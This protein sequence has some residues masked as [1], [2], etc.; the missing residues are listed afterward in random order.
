MKLFID[1]TNW[2]LIFILIKDEQII[3]Q[4]LLDNT[5]KI[6]DIFFDSLNLFLKRNNLTLKMLNDFYLTIGPGSYT[7][8]RIGLSMVKTLKVLNP[9]INVFVVDSLK[10]QAGNENKISLINAR[11]NKFYASVLSDYKIKEAIQLIN[12]DQVDTLFEQYVQKGYIQVIDYQNV[13]FGL[14]VLDLIKHN[15]FVLIE[16]VEDLKPIY[17][18]NFI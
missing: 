17:I 12:Q 10:F 2:K 6:S 1:T 7:G 11:S 9:Q 14:N 18:K 13:D 4:F 3:D 5:K 8:V 15:Q 16:K